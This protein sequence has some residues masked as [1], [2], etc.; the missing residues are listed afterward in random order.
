MAIDDCPHFWTLLTTRRVYNTSEDLRKSKMDI[1]IEIEYE[2]QGSQADRDNFISLVLPHAH[3]WVK[4][5]VEALDS[6]IIDR[7]LSIETP[8]LEKLD[9][10]LI[11]I[12]FGEHPSHCIDKYLGGPKLRDCRL[13][14][15][16]LPSV[17]NSGLPYIVF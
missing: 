16:V 7:F 17:L 4:L 15:V 9:V 14:C 12:P 3:R 6:D 5:R 10:E 2:M 8:G 13:A 11:F 1:P